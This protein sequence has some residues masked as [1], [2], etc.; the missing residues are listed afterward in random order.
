M[1]ILNL[2]FVALTFSTLVAGCG[3]LRNGSVSTIVPPPGTLDATSVT[4]L[5]SGYTVE[6]RLDS[7]GRVSLTYYNPNGQLRQLQEG[8]KR[9]GVWR[10]RDDGR[11]CLKFG[12]EKE[13]CRIIVKEGNSY[14][15]YVVKKNN[16]HERVLTYTS[17]HPGNQVD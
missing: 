3:Q 14:A 8:A 2:L 17:F 9:D 4:A 11:I 10:V 16:M 1:K 7:S 6:S 5:F 15:K 12:T 13:K